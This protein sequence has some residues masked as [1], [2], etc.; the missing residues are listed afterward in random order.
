[1]GNILDR[2]LTVLLIGVV[3]YGIFASRREKTPPPRPQYGLGDTAPKIPGIDYASSSL[4]LVVFLRT[5]CI[6]CTESL[7][8]YAQ[9]V[10]DRDR[11]G[12]PIRIV[13]I[14]KEAEED[15]R[16]YLNKHSVKFDAIAS[17]TANPWAKL[18]STPTLILVD[19][20][21]EV[22][23]MW[24]GKL[25]EDGQA[26]LRRELGLGPAPVTALR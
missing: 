24:V 3:V 7:P 25:A 13:G 12:V 26:T 21:G 8:F 5:T 14:T 11:E 1:M 6:Y 4:T 2:S 20:L 19:R 23:R 9:V 17:I 22:R 15:L 10:K 16:T 18:A